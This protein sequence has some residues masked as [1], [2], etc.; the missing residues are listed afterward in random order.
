MQH[1]TVLPEPRWTV[2]QGRQGSSGRVTP[3]LAAE[4]QLASEA[5]LEQLEDLRHELVADVG[6]QFLVGRVRD[7]AGVDQLRQVPV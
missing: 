1:P 5:G 7:D 2:R 3:S 6:E 4:D